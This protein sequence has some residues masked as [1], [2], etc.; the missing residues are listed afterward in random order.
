M[1][2]SNRTKRRLVARGAETHLLKD[3]V[4]TFQSASQALEKSYSDL[5]DRV[6]ILS[7]DLER[8]REQRIRLERLA[9][10][11][12]MAMELA[13]EIRN[14]LAS[15]ELFASMLEGNYAEQIVRS[16]RLLNHSVTNV[17][18][19]GKPI[20]PSPTRFSVNALLEGIRGFIQPLAAQK[21]IRLEVV[22]EPDCTLFADHE[23]MH[24]M[25]LNLV[26]N[27][28]RETPTNGTIRM[29]ASHGVTITV[30]DSGPGIPE[31]TIARIFDP[32]FS[33]HREGCGLGLPIVKRI[34]DS[35][36]G[37]IRVESSQ[38][39]TRFVITLLRNTEVVSEPPT[40]S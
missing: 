12:E 29:T 38:S 39:G 4:L 13:H 2:G 5:Q 18:H 14:P 10:M 1:N 40:C 28:L 26:L 25:L 34:V 11:G 23:L 3:L 7:E 9:A 20:V 32:M 27:A 22:T 33:T 37:M 31:A 21:H 8:E 30:E 24:R 36:N 15:I 16:V 35:H 19:F 6:R 17:L